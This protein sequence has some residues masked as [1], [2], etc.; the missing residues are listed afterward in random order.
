MGKV[1]RTLGYLTDYMMVK[2]KLS[3]AFWTMMATL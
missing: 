2:A 1:H 3:R